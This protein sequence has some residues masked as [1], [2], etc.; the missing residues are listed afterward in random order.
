MEKT[1]GIIK[2]ARG[3]REQARKVVCSSVFVAISLSRIKKESPPLFSPKKKKKKKG[4][5]VF[6]NIHVPYIYMKKN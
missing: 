1:P 2:K 3:E 4:E 6:F 5:R